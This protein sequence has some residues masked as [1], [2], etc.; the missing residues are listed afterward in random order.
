MEAGEILTF[1]VN[2]NFFRVVGGM[3]ENKIENKSLKFQK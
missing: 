1:A 3:G 2:Y